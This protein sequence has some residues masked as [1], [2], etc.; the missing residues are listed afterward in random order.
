MTAHPHDPIQSFIFVGNIRVGELLTKNLKASGYEVA[1]EI[2]DADIVLIYCESQVDLEDVL[3]ES[4]GLIQQASPDTYLLNLSPSTPNFAKELNAVALV[5]DLRPVE[6]PLFVNNPYD[7]Q[8]FSSANLSCFLAGD[9]KDIRIVTPFVGSFADTV[10]VTGLTG[11]SQL[12]HAALTIR[13]SADITAAMEAEA[14]YRASKVSS[15]GL[16]VFSQKEGFCN[17]YEADLLRAVK[18]ECFKGDYTI[19][20]WINELAAALMAADDLEL[21]LPGAEASM[22]L[23]EL[24]IIIG[25]NTMNPAVLSLVYGE[26]SACAKHGLDWTRAEEA[27]R[28]ENHVHT[29]DCDCEQ[30]DGDEDFLGGFG[31]YSSN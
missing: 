7:E 29:D 27:Y 28:P 20:I 22:H 16:A 24:L 26:E 2:E 6:A 11:S 12:A 9:E 25:G 3:F 10:E 17:D 8:A 4:N 31:T 15:D 14:L 5:S 30:E 1:S 23:L 13:R 19:E 21:I 18:E